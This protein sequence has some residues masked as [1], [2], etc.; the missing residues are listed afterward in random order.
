MRNVYVV[1]KEQLVNLGMIVRIS[2]YE[3]RATY[4]SH[5]LGLMWQ[6]LNPIIQIGI[7]YLIFGVGLNGG[8]KID[9]TPFFVWLLLGIVAW[10]FIRGTLLSGST[11]ILKKIAMVSKMKFPVSILPSIAMASQFITYLIMMGILLVVLLLFKIPITV[12]WLQYI[13]YLFSMLVFLY[14]AS[15]L[16]ATITVLIRDYHLVLQSVIQVLFY[17]SGVI[18]DIKASYFPLWLK[19]VIE[20]NPLFYIIDGFR[21]TF[22]STQWFWQKEQVTLFFWLLVMLLLLVGTQLHMRFRKRFIDYI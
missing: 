5:Y 2:K 14:A 18:I 20:L 8:R 1:I 13:Y 21:D 16:N 3:E 4:Q 17:L 12:Y 9:G 15:L 6:I 7:Y 19:K 10:F 22:L 11:S